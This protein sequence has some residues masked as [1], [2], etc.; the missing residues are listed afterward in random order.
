VG[1][2]AAEVQA[3]AN[4]GETFGVA[5]GHFEERGTQGGAA[6]QAQND[7][8]GVGSGGAGEAGLQGARLR[9]QQ[10]AV[11]VQDRDLV[12]SIHPPHPIAAHRVRAPAL[13]L[14]AVWPTD[15]PTGRPRKKLETRLAAPWATMSV[16]GCVW[17]SAQPR[18]TGFL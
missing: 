17:P 3:A 10:T 8:R 15:P 13:T 6:A 12:T 4:L 11:H 14:S 16:C 9:V 7:G 2:E 5:G 1:I 18:R